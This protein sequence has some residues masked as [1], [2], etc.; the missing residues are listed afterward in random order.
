MPARRILLEVAVTSPDDAKAAHAGGADRLELCCALELGGL[1]PS[2]GTLL[3]VKRATPLPVLALLRPRPGGFAYSSSEFRVLQR[4]FDL[5][6][7]NGADG[8]VL[9][10]L[11]DDGSVDRPRCA[12]LVRQ[13]AGRPVVFH[14]AFDVT[15]EPL[16]AL[17]ALI[18]LGVRRVLTSGQAPSA[19][20]G[21]SLIAELVRRSA[22]RIEV[23]PGGGVNADSAPGLISRAGCEQVHASCRGRRRDAS[24][25]ARPA[26]SFGSPARPE[27]HFNVTDADAVRRLRGVLD[28]DSTRPAEGVGQSPPPEGPT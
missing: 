6:L 1:T 4:D 11:A 7:A 2:P 20:S 5:A 12:A 27:G 16:A 18:D 28:R 19:P 14:R 3:E 22:G 26:V 10:V 25:A 13:A 24:T 9:G 23:L 17:E 15:P 21:A 8:I